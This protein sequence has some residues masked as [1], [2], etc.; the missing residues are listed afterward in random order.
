MTTYGCR[1]YLT[2]IGLLPGELVISEVRPRR[3]LMTDIQE[4]TARHF[5]VPLA[6]MTSSRRS[7]DVARPRQVAMWLCKHLTPHSLPEIGRRFGDRDHTT[8]IH[9]IRMVDKL[10]GELAEIAHAVDVLSDEL[11]RSPEGLFA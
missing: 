9:A 10:R 6:S 5:G 11:T 3:L 7:R 4:A 1:E 2:K 8:V